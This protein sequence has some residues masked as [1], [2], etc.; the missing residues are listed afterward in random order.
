MTLRAGIATLFLLATLVNA[1][2][3]SG[4]SLT[5]LLRSVDAHYPSV[6]AALSETEAARAGETAAEGA[7]DLKLKFNTRNA[8]LGFYETRVLE[9]LVEQPLRYRG[10]KL[11]GGWRRGDGLFPFQEEKLETQSAGEVLFGA[12]TALLRNGAIDQPRADLQR[13][14][15]AIDFQSEAARNIRL[16]SQQ[17]ATA[18][19]LQWEAAARRLVIYQDLL[20]L[21]LVRDKGL[22]DQIAIGEKAKVDAT[23]NARQIAA[24]RE[25]LLGAGQKLDAEAVKL[26]LY[27]RDASGRPVVPTNPPVEDLFGPGFV[28]AVTNHTAL[29]ARHPEMLAMQQL[30]A[31]ERVNQA[32]YD[33]QLLPR[34]DLSMSVSKD[35]G[36]GSKTKEN[37]E[38]RIGAAFEFPFQNRKARGSLDASTSKL[39]A[40]GQK[41]SLLFDQLRARLQIAERNISRIKERIEQLEERRDLTVKMRKAEDDRV[42]LRL[43]DLL[44]LNLREEDVAKAEVD[45]IEARLELRLAELERIAALGIDLL[46]PAP[47]ASPPTSP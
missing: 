31:A 35:L 17:A 7:F 1:Q 3:L 22:R 9:A 13:S 20:D 11:Y 6:L 26:S 30:V 14:A 28:P 47:P 37:G 46:N 34:L 40:L 45:L 12:S 15:I 43:S 32:L 38:F 10:T 42:A 2:E 27:W 29:L 5:N 4:V 33:N 19:L 36:I 44:R 23:D 24:R 39:A 18:Q 25:N 41:L 16:L 21:A 8:P